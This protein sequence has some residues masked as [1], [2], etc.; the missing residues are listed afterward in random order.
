MNPTYLIID[1]NIWIYLANGDLKDADGNIVHIKVFNILKQLVEEGDVKILVSPIILDEFNKNKS[2]TQKYINKLNGTITERE[3]YHKNHRDDLSED[4]IKEIQNE[5][6]LC[7]QKIEENKKHI[8]NVESFLKSNKVSVIPLSESV[9]TKCFDQALAKKAPFIGKKSNSMADMAILLSAVEYIDTRLSIKVLDDLFLRPQS[10]F[11]SGNITD[12]SQDKKDNKEQ[13][14]PDLLQFFKSVDMRYSI[15]LGTT[16]NSI[17]EIQISNEEIAEMDDFLPYD[18]IDCPNCSGWHD[19]MGVLDN[20]SIATFI[21]ENIP[22]PAPKEQL[23]LPFE[24]SI[25]ELEKEKLHPERITTIM[26][27]QCNWCNCQFF[28]CPIC[29]NLVMYDEE[30]QCDDCDTKY[31]CNDTYDRKGLLIKQTIRMLKWE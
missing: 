2:W 21:D 14:H 22:I 18:Y 1:T 29:G 31:E 15:S 10:I 5:I 24:Y 3:N 25:E 17:S 6:T 20:Q 7:K 19:G 9:K 8:H 4:E 26:L 27:L 23:T 30:T 12:F 11:I 28:S 13:I 16:L